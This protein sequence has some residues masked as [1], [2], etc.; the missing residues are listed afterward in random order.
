V[1]GDVDT[2]L[3]D[4][5]QNFIECILVLITHDEMASQENDSHDKS[6]ILG[7]E[8]YKAGDVAVLTQTAPASLAN[9][10]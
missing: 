7:D 3:T 6:W 10:V 2:V 8:H 5:Q 9:T 1:V 4:P